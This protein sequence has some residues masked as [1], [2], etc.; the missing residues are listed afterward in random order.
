M[1]ID[2]LWGLSFGNGLQLQPSDTLFFT[3]GP[4]AETNGLFGKI[5]AQ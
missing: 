1:T 3:A 4:N 5:E 2:G